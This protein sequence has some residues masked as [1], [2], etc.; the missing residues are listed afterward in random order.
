MKTKTYEDDIRKAVVRAL[1]HYGITADDVEMPSYANGMVSVLFCKDPT[2]TWRKVP[3]MIPDEVLADMIH[4][5]KWDGDA[6]DD[7]FRFGGG[8]YDPV[9]FECGVE[10]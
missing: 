10:G 7:A 2:S 4:G 1:S 8:G 3:L 6:S 5:D 9:W